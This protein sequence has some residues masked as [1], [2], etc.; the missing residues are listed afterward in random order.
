MQMTCMSCAIACM[1]DLVL[2]LLHSWHALE[3]DLNKHTTAVIRLYIKHDGQPTTCFQEICAVLIKVQNDNVQ[4]QGKSVLSNMQF[5][6]FTCRLHDA[7]HSNSKRHGYIQLW[8][9]SHASCGLT[10]KAGQQSI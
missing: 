5:A 6:A 8:T 1:Q 2:K 3:E 4:S 10:T 9:A 7:P